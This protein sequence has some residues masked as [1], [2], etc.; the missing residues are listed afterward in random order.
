MDEIGSRWDAGCTTAWVQQ[1]VF[2]GLRALAVIAVGSGNREVACTVSTGLVESQLLSLYLGIVGELKTLNGSGAL[3]AD[4]P[5]NVGNCVGLVSQVAVSNI[6]NAHVAESLA[7]SHSVGQTSLDICVRVIGSTSLISILIFALSFG[8]FDNVFKIIAVLIITTLNV[9]SELG[10]LADRTDN[11]LHVVSLATDQAAE[12]K[13]NTL[14]LVTL[15]EDSAVGMLK[16]GEL[17]LV[18]LAFTLKLLGNLLLE[19]KRLESIVTL[20]FSTR[21]ASSEASSIVLLLINE[22]SKTPVLALVVLNLNLKIL[23]LLC[24]LLSERLE[25]EELQRYQLTFCF[26]FFSSLDDIPVASSSPA[27]RQGSCFS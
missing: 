1:A 25:F 27:P 10:A 14:S 19:N 23:R 17:L 13:N 24:K 9:V 22:T 11:V 3:L 4:V 20:L 6:D 16:C 18:A 15:S 21:E 5:D 26:H 7:V 2:A 12:M 8:V